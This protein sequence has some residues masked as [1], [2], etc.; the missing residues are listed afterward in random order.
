MKRLYNGTA[1]AALSVMLLMPSFAGAQNGSSKPALDPDAIAALQRMGE[2]LRTLKVFQ[3]KGVITID[4]VL[5]DSQ[6]IQLTKV[7][8]LLASR[9][10]NLFVQ[11]KSDN[12]ERQFLY[13]GSSFTLFAPLKNMYSTVTA[14]PN[15][16]DL[17]KL[18]E[19]KHGIETPLVDLFRWGT[20]ESELAA[21]TVARDVGSSVCDGSTCQHYAFRQPGL[22]WE[23]WIQK[24]DYP[25][26]RK[27][28]LTTMT[29]EARPQHTATYSWN[30]APSFN[31][32]TF[33]FVAP[34][35]GQKI[36]LV[37][38]TAPKTTAKGAKE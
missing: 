14:P 29:D 2:Y 7:V 36:P 12:F 15:I 10:N 17:A 5:A 37:D 35:N 20:P 31:K 3:V 25:L 24:G 21:I 34:E 26:P 13:D 23:I 33:V 11:I 1:M 22:D 38:L 8:D 27:I 9:P 28:V 19:E 16:N 30:L 4:Q 32:E 6:K 18:L